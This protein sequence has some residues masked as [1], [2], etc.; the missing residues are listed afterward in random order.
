MTNKQRDDDDERICTACKAP[1]PC[2]CGWSDERRP[3]SRERDDT[4]GWTYRRA[5][6]DE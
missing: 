1:V 4:R 3:R 6:N 5:S 2:R